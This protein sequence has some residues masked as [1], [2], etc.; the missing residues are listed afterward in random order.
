MPEELEA[1]TDEM[2]EE[3]PVSS[4]A[5]FVL[6]KGDMEI[7]R[8]IYEYRFLRREHISA[9]TGRPLKRLH[10]PPLQARQKRL[11]GI[12]PVAATEA[13]LCPGQS[14]LARSRRAGN[15]PHPSS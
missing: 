15:S 2:E 9:L 6:T 13:H 3:E 8:L 7:F 10:R 11:P 1:V 12:N 14:G 5:G 4:P